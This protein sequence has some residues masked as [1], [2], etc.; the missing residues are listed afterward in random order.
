MQQGSDSEA[1]F[2]RAF[3]MKVFLF[4]ASP[5]YGKI[6]TDVLLETTLLS[7]LIDILY[8][9]VQEYF[10]SLEYEYKSV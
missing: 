3:V 7:G 5:L 8:T 10:Y 9:T 1:L 4:L 2:G 6:P